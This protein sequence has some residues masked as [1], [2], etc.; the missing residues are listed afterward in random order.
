MD[1]TFSA[2]IAGRSTTSIR[3]TD[4]IT[5]TD[6]GIAAAASGADRRSIANPQCLGGTPVVPPDSAFG[7]RKDR[8]RVCLDLT[9]VNPM[10]KSKKTIEVITGEKV[11]GDVDPSKAVK[12]KSSR[13]P[14]ADE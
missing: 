6:A 2:R 4:T 5:G 7:N 9:G 11:E 8:Q 10:N 3:A 12:G 14:D 1:P 13:R